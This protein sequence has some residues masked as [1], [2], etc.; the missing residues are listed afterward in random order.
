MGFV[1][2]RLKKADIVT[3]LSVGRHLAPA[4]I[5]VLYFKGSAC[6]QKNRNEGQEETTGFEEGSSGI[7]GEAKED[8][9]V[10]VGTHRDG[11]N[12]I[13]DLGHLAIGFLLRHTSRHTLVEKHLE[14]A[15]TLLLVGLVGLT[16]LSDAAKRG[17]SQCLDMRRRR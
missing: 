5:E 4:A 3:L 8:R 12:D 2:L 6:S 14:G 11:R 10:A 17:A 1:E 16:H 13:T 15:H 9:V 7:V